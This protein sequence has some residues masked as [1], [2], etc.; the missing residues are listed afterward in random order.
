MKLF[1]CPDCVTV[2]DQAG[3]GNQI[4]QL[5]PDHKACQKNWDIWGIG[6]ITRPH[7]RSLDCLAC[8]GCGGTPRDELGGTMRSVYERAGTM[9]AWVVL[10]CDAIAMQ[11]QPKLPQRDRH[12]QRGHL[13]HLI[14]MRWRNDVACRLWAKRWLNSSDM[15]CGSKWS[16]RVYFIFEISLQQ[17]L[18]RLC[19]WSL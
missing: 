15:L 9:A 2:A 4:Q 3:T 11:F 13:L 16:L 1:P 10:P 8:C 12:R 6:N 7:A 19:E 14:R 5:D 17:E 18:A